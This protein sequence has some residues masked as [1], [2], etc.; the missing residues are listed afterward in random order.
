MEDTLSHD[1][2]VWKYQMSQDLMKDSINALSR[3]AQGRAHVCLFLVRLYLCTCKI[4]F[5]FSI[6]NPSWSIPTPGKARFQNCSGS[7][8][9][10]PHCD[11]YTINVKS[12]E[13]IVL[14]AQLKYINGGSRN[15]RVTTMGIFKEGNGRQ[16]YC[17]TTGCQ[18]NSRWS[19]D[20]LGSEVVLSQASVNDNGRYTIHYEVEVPGGG[21]VSDLHWNNIDVTVQMVTTTTGD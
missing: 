10:T 20:S 19:Q 8:D 14:P 6:F 15:Q 1:L 16:Y 13:D 11:G 12:G 3:G 21:G 5:C 4:C 18:D 9:D 17:T 7:S 2:R